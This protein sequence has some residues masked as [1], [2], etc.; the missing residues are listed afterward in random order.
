MKNARTGLLGGSFNPPHIGHLRLCI[1]LLEQAELDTIQLIPA[2]IPPH[3]KV[4][5]IL[6]F[7]MRCAMLEAAIQDHPEL[8]VNRME[9]ER[10]GPS[11][12]FDTL[13]TSIDRSPDTNFTFILGDNDLLTMEKWYKGKEIG[14]L[15][16]LTVAGRS[17]AD[18]A[19][20]DIFINS[21]WNV[22]RHNTGRW[23]ILN[24]GTVRYFSV[25]ILDISSSMIRSRW[26][27]G[28]KID[29]LV[30]QTVK[31]YLESYS[32]E[33]RKTWQA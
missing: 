5:N 2:H 28:K 11:F 4:D 19:E 27:S 7:D 17:G 20:L 29:W 23:D 14:M 10:T 32:Q 1:E 21:F 15:C 3:K 16:D 8:S 33:I 12:T 6:P 25:P 9:R 24:G 30:P 13:Q 26:L 31:V 18:P 22:K